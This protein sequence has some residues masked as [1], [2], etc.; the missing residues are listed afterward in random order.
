VPDADAP[1]AA[2]LAAAGAV[3]LGKL[4]M[5]E[6]AVGGTSQN[7]HYGDARNPWDP[8]RVPGGSSGGSG[9]VTAAGIAVAAL[10]SD[11]G[12]SVRMPA[13]LCGVSGLRPT[14]GRVS[15][16]GSVPCAWSFDTIGP[17][18]RRVEDVAA[19]FDVIAG[20]D[21]DDPASLDVQLA[22]AVPGLA[23][24]A[25]GLRV[26]VLGG[27]FRAP[28]LALAAGAALDA[29]A[30][31]LARAGAE[32]ASAELPGH[33][34]M[35]AL[36]GDMLLADAAAFHAERLTRQPQGFG[37][38]ILARL[39]RGAAVS[40]PRYAQARQAQ[41]AWRRRVGELLRAH[42]ALLC[43]AC[44]GPAP[45][46]V[47]SDPIDTTVELAWFS[48]VWSLAGV[49]ALVL[50]AGFEAGLP[51]GLQLVGRPWEEATLLRLGHAYQQATD[52]HL[53]LPPAP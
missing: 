39:K 14:Y 3:S 44:P 31:V 42:D 23:R 52:W 50:P 33:P 7:D 5:A 2:A 8:D 15:N 11:T 9:I 53:R 6:W 18:A 40:G 34:E 27:S 16:R 49:P 37:P 30:E 28:P 12:G 1:V 29:A 24:G 4:S 41:R 19:V 25:G 43:P 36:T 17:L 26:G 51:L 32:V 21:P 20:Y 48:S 45:L 47:E 35:A 13:S 10:G 38:R 22:P 46:I